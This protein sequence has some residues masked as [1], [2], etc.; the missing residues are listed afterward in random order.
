MILTGCASHAQHGNH[1]AH[2]LQLMTEGKV[3]DYT[4]KDPDRLLRLCKQ[5]GIETEGRDVF[6]L[7]GELT[8]MALQDFSRLKGEGEAAW[9]VK[10]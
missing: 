8:G 1:I 3:P 4:I 5:F 6:E 7:A 9:I 10:K 2:V